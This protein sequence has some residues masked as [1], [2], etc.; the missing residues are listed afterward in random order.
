MMT[1]LILSA[2]IIIFILFSCLK[3]I[4][5]RRKPQ[6]FESPYELPKL[7][8]NFDTLTTLNGNSEKDLNQNQIYSE[9]S[10]IYQAYTEPDYDIV[11]NDEIYQELPNNDMIFIHAVGGQKI[12][13]YDDDDYEVLPCNKNKNTDYEEIGF[14]IQEKESNE[15]EKIEDL[16]GEKIY[17]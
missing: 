12:N 5:K 11:K 17:F 3:F 14:N 6:K 1:N 7:T 10:G 16:P 2:I 13:N 4:F 15:I 9:A 8:K